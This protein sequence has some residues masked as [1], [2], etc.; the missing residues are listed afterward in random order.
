MHLVNWTMHATMSDYRQFGVA[1][2]CFFCFFTFKWSGGNLSVVSAVAGTSKLN[3]DW[4]WVVAW[5]KGFHKSRFPPWMKR[6]HPYAQACI[7]SSCT[8][9]KIVISHASPDPAIVQQ[10]FSCLIVF[11]RGWQGVHYSPN[12][13]FLFLFEP[14]VFISCAIQLSLEG[15]SI[16]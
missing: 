6:A 4:M 13:R 12:G 15:G 16:C 7:L 9:H 14:Y 8:H 11:V 2:C 10:C 5:R 3:G 1:G